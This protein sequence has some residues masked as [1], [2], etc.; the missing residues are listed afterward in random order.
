ML[1]SV[2]NEIHN[3]IVRSNVPLVQ[4]LNFDDYVQALILVERH[5]YSFSKTEHRR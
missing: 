1:Y 2:Y 4:G 5:G 3:H